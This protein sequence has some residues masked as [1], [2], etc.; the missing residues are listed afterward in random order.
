[1][2]ET[3]VSYGNRK[4][5]GNGFLFSSSFVLICCQLVGLGSLYNV[6]YLIVQT[7][8]LA[9]IVSSPLPYSVGESLI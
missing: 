6:E 1:M 9:P 7:R 3:G 4:T 8:G 2:A 5:E